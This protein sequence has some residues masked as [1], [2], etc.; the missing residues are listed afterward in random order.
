MNKLLVAAVVVMFFVASGAVWA[1][2]SA[3]TGSTT[4]TGYS[5]NVSLDGSAV[6][7]RVAKEYDESKVDEEELDRWYMELMNLHFED[8]G[9]LKYIEGGA[10]TAAD[11]KK[12]PSS[13]NS[14]TFVY[15]YFLEGVLTEDFNGLTENEQFKLLDS[16]EVG[17]YEFYWG[18]QFDVGNLTLTNDSDTY[19]ITYESLTKNG[20]NYWSQLKDPWEDVREEFKPLSSNLTFEPTHKEFEIYEYMGEQYLLYED[21]HTAEANTAEAFG[22]SVEE[23]VQVYTNMEEWYVEQYQ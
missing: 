21:P 17:S 3:L 23:A 2:V 11:I 22:I 13:I 12:V 16:V 7:D 20:E 15:T 14:D 9:L 4:S 18:H 10:V 1:A 8:V 6:I 5:D 19:T